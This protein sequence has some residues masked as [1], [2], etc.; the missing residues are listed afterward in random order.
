VLSLSTYA[1]ALAIFLLLYQLKERALISAPA[2]GAAALALCLRLLALDRKLDM[3]AG[4]CAFVA[5]LGVAEV[6]WPLNYWILGTLGG[7]LALLLAF[8]VAVGVVRQV[9]AGPF[10]QALALEWGGVSLA[11]LAVVYGASRL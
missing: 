8:Y 5:G 2:A 9:L 6:L 1:V 7:G 10:T 3:Q 4:V 11:G